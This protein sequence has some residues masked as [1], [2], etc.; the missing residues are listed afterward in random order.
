MES[1]TIGRRGICKPFYGRPPIAK[2]KLRPHTWETMAV[3][4]DNPREVNGVQIHGVTWSI[5]KHCFANAK[6][7]SM[8]RG[9]LRGKKIRVELYQQRSLGDP[10]LLKMYSAA[11]NKNGQ[12][13]KVGAFYIWS[14]ALGTWPYQ[15]RLEAPLAGGRRGQ[16][17][18]YGD[19]LNG[20]E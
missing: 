13:T 7:I 18:W 2:K 16:L 12:P 15:F 3:G 20:L 6:Q 19:P 10:P 8:C 11:V 9:S 17:A 1:S 14:R 4:V 5:R